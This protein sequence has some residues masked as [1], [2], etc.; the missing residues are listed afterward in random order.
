MGAAAVVKL[1][2]ADLVLG[3]EALYW[4]TFSFM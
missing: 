2:R 1:T 3:L 4:H